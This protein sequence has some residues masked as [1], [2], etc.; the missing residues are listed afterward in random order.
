M[1]T[2]TQPRRSTRY[3]FHAETCNQMAR[4]PAGTVAAQAQ[5]RGIAGAEPLLVGLDC[6]LRYAE[7]YGRRFERPLNEDYVL[8]VPFLEA[9]KGF[10][11][12]LNGDGAEAMRI[13][14][15]TDSKDNGACEGVFWEAMKA[16]GFTE[17]DI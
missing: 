6:L 10:R 2:T 3:H 12:L 13:G 16:G 9:A 14:L 4:V 11:G 1:T 15:T 17:S 5:D 8:R 7:A